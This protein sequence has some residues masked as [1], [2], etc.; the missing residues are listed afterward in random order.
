MDNQQKKQ[1]S[2][3]PK[4]QFSPPQFFA[5]SAVKF[6]VK[7]LSGSF[8]KIAYLMTAHIESLVS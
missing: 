8:T 1:S 6:A 4:T 3:L 7:K 5:N 2:S